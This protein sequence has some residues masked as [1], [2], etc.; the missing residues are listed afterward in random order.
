MVLKKKHFPVQNKKSNKTYFCFA[1]PSDLDQAYAFY[2]ARYKDMSFKE[3]LELG[4]TDFMKK[5]ASI[6]E[7]EPLYT[8]IK[9][10]TIDLSKIKDKDERKYWSNLKR[11]H[12][13]PSEYLPI[14]E[15]M[16]D[17]NKMIKEK[18]I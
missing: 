6:P 8:I 10:R 1:Y 11:I 17:L 4:I 13:I 16:Q 14:E 12:S 3:F 7:S 5:L 9:S 18:K 2:C 15:I